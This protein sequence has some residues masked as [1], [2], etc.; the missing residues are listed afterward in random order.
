[1]EKNKQQVELTPEEQE[2]KAIEWENKVLRV[3]LPGVGS[4]AFIIG[5]VG[6]IITVSSNAGV[7]VF[8]LIVAILGI[9]GIAYGVY[10]LVMKK[11]R[12]LRKKETVPSDKPN[13][14]PRTR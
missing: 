14:R 4:I 2:L 13:D 12:K 5:L 11:K 8:L 1:M 6:F 7:A 9:G 10:H 3:L